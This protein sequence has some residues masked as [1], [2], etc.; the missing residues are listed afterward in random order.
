MTSSGSKSLSYV[1]IGVA[2]LAAPFLFPTIITQLSVGW[3]MILLALTWDTQG[4][5]MGYNSFGNILYFGIGTYVCIAVQVGMVT[6]LGEYTAAGGAKAVTFT[7]EQY[8]TGLGVGMIAGAVVAVIVAAILGSGILGLRGHYFAIATLGL[9]I[10]AG[11]LA[12]GWELIG[13]GSGISAPVFP[14]ALG[15]RSFFFYFFF[16]IL[17][18]ITFFCLKWI[19]AGRFGLAINAI[20]DD[21]LV[22]IG[23]FPGFG[24]WSVRVAGRFRRSPRYRFRR[25]HFRGLDGV[26]GH[27]G[28]QGNNLGA[29]NRRHY[30]PHHPGIVLDLFARLAAGCAGGSYR[31]HCRLFSQGNSGL[32]AGR[33]AGKIW[34]NG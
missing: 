30:F 29:G 17:A 2:G 3:L 20:R 6:D 34:R 32:G 25:H 7:T 1:V 27:I 13:A 10:A 14:D 5:Q 8:L 4:G 28:W 33:L 15:D 31:R 24:W 11:E 18:V 9:G 19:Y 12:G 16:F 21:I 23:V 26:D 22:C